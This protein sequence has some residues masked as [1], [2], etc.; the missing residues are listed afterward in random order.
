MWI[1]MKTTYTGPAGAFI[2]DAPYDLPEDTLKQLPKGSYEQTKAP[3]DMSKEEPAA[4]NKQQKTPKNK[5]Q[6]GSKNK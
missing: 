6:T 3:W 1:R 4:G 2:G 5:Q